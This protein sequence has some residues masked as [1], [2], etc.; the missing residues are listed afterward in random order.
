MSVA[1]VFLV[2]VSSGALGL[3]ALSLLL[4]FDLRVCGA[5][6]NRQRGGDGGQTKALTLGIV[7]KPNESAKSSAGNLVTSKT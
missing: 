6:P 2:G 3:L 7:I 5:A 1:D 4:E